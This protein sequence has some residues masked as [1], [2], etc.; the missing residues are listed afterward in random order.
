MDPMAAQGRERLT[1]KLRFRLA[2]FKEDHAQPTITH[3]ACLAVRQ[4]FAER[5]VSITFFVLMRWM[6]FVHLHNEVILSPSY[7]SA[8][9]TSE[10][11]L[12]ACLLL[13]SIFS[14]HVISSRCAS[15]CSGMA[16]G[17]GAGGP[18]ILDL[19]SGA[20]SLKDKFIDVWTA[21]NVTGQNPLTR[22]DVAVYG[23]VTQRLA[24]LVEQTFGVSGVMLTAPTFF[25]RISAD[26][27]PIIPNDEYW[28]PH[29]DKTQYGSFIYTVLVYL[30]S[31]HEEFEGGS[32]H[33]LSPKGKKVEAS[34]SPMPGTV[35]LF[36][37]GHENPHRVAQVTRG[38]RLALTVAFTCNPD[39]AIR[40]FLGRAVPD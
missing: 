35:V 24:L 1:Q 19:Q 20:L 34:V 2:R 31:S 6:D 16:L 5:I 39:L 14:R 25:S 37:S 21:F 18:T 32:L 15:S 26:R 7:V 30:S 12:L 29:V 22:S 36:T 17:G 8:S 11:T 33:F 10:T 27:P 23:K 28:H 4:R 9:V 40:D 13:S 3:R 38:T